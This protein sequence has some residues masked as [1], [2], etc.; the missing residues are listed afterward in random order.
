MKQ[1]QHFLCLILACTFL[2]FSQRIAAQNPQRFTISGYVTDAE[3][4][5]KL[6]TATVYD[7]LTKQG[8]ITNDYGFF[9]LTLK[10]GPVELVSSFSGY[11]PFQTRFVLNQDTTITLS[12]GIFAL[13]EVEIVAEEEER[14]EQKTEM[15]TIDVPIQQ[16]RKLP[17][18]LGEVDVIKA[19][20]LMPG[21]K[22]GSEGTT[23]MYVRGGGPDQNLILLDGVPLYYVSHLGGFFSVFNADALSSVKLVKGGFPARY[24]GRLSSVLDIRM[25]EGNINKFEGEGS[26]G[27]ISSKLSFQGPIIK[28][29]TSFIVSGRRTY[30]DLFS[31]PISKAVSKG[32]TSFGYYFHDFN[33]KVNHTFSDKDRLYLSFYLG[34][35]NLDLKEKYIAGKKGD[36]NYSSNEFKNRIGWGNDLAALRWNHIWSPRLFSNLTA[37]YSKY[38]LGIRY[39]EKSEF[40]QND[41]L[42]SSSSFFEYISGIRDW[43]AKL[44]FDFYPVPSHDI[45][46]GINSTFHKFTPGSLGYRENSGSTQIDTTLKTKIH[47]TIETSLYIEDNFQIGRRFS[48]NI[49]VHAVNYQVSEQSLFS[50]QPRASFRL[51]LTDKMSFKGSYVQMTQFIHLLTNSTV[52]LPIDLWVPATDKVPSQSSWQAAGGLAT[53]LWEDQF[54]VSVEG[55]YKK[56]EGLIAFKEGTNFFLG[57]INEGTWE[58]IVETGGQGEAYGAELL[59]QKKKGKTTGWIGYTLSWNFRQFDELNGG[60]KFPDRYDRRH[61]LSVVVSHA[62]NERISVAGTW[63]FGTGNAITLPSGNYA[64][65]ENWDFWGNNNTGSFEPI[66]ISSALWGDFSARLYENGRNGFR[67]EPYHRL[68]LGVNLTKKTKWGER[69]WNFGIYNA[70]NRL[71]PFA[72]YIRN[73]YDSNTQTYTPKLKKLSLFP[74]IPSVSYSF[75]F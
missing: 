2:T 60:L 24:G 74:V 57:G 49:G 38:E 22:S 18:L 14:I 73:D 42:R 41:T 55:Y 64:T 46:F 23:G 65:L 17:A 8:S 34:D 16:I 70:Y 6:I 69:T 29:K 25:K 32:N 35:D 4:G 50:I 43:A 12:L 72:Y 13:E 19:I 59:V 36:A 33:A 66:S 21:V 11:K 75:K 3:T 58:N 63:V 27:L 53:S 67:M 28:G 31:R 30:F 52:G 71:N 62:F 54:E 44:D 10:S 26:I 51:Q 61:D 56:M 1:T 40:M 47:N 9:S 20:Q 5:E 48:A 45:K 39:D 7:N 37:T 15:S 68:D